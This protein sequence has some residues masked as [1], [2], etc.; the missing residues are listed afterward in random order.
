MYAAKWATSARFVKVTG[1]LPAPMIVIF[2]FAMLKPNGLRGVVSQSALVSPCEISR[3][4]DEVAERAGVIAREGQ[5]DGLE[6]L[7]EFNLARDQAVCRETLRD[8]TK[9]SVKRGHRDQRCARGMKQSESAHD[10]TKSFTPAFFAASA[11]V[12]CA[13]QPP[14]DRADTTTSTPLSAA[15]TEAW[16]A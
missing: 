1:A 8:G 5:S 10:G 11:R 9:L 14:P 2:L 3:D 6:M 16:S 7:N 15:A 12:G 4:K 13:A